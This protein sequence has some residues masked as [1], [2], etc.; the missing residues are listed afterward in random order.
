[1]AGAVGCFFSLIMVGSMIAAY[2]GTFDVNPMPGHVAIGKSL[3]AGQVI[4]LLT[5]SIRLHLRR[6]LLILVGSHRM[7]SSLGDFQSLDSIDWCFNHYIMHLDE[8]LVRIG[9]FAS[10]PELMI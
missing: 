10:I 1:M 9:C 5:C 2:G 3:F 4:Q 8:Q 6:L 7:G